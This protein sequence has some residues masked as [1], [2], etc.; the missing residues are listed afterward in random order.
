[1]KIRTRLIIALLV[2]LIAAMTFGTA[3]VWSSWRHSQEMNRIVT[4]AELSTRISSLVHETQ[5]ERGT[6]AG[7]LGNKSDEFRAR[8]QTQRTATDGQLKQ[9][10]GF[11][12][13]ISADDFGAEFS[14]ELTKAL[15]PLDKLTDVRKR[16]SAL[17]IPAPEAIGYYT[18]ANTSLL[19]VIGRAAT[20]TGDGP[21]AIRI[22]A[23]TSF[24]KSKERA[25]IERAVL[26]N[27][28]AQDSF[29]PG[30]YEK[31]QQLVALQDAY[32]A[33]FANHSSAQDRELLSEKLKAPCV[34]H[35]GEFRQKAIAT[36]ATG[37]FGVKATE[38][39]DT[40]TAKINLLKEVDDGLASRLLTEAR[41]TRAASDRLLYSLAGAMLVTLAVSSGLAYRLARS[42]LRRV[43][44][45]RDRLRGIAEG[46]AD[47]TLRLES[48]PDELGEVAKWFNKFM[49]RLEPTIGRILT[50]SAKVCVSAN[51]LTSTARALAT[52]AEE[53]KLGASSVASAVEELSSNMKHMASSTER[54]ADDMNI[55]A[56]SVR[57]MNGSIAG[58]AGSSVESAGVVGTA[59]E[60]VQRSNEQI[61]EFSTAAEAIGQVVNVIQDIAEQT[62]LLAL[63]AT[64]EA[65]RAGNAGRGF[66]VV[67][68][69][70][71]E[72][73]SQTSTATED[74]RTRISAIQVTA[75]DTVL[76]MG[77]IREVMT[78]IDEAA[79]SIA[80]AA[81]QQ[82]GAVQQIAARVAH[83]AETSQIIS[84]GV[85]QSAQACSEISRHIVNV[86]QVL[87]DTV[88]GA[89]RSN[90]AGQQLSDVANDLLTLMQGFKIRQADLAEATD[91]TAA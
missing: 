5:K 83:V 89:Q 86:D 87:Q 35:V 16:V 6:T 1:M 20:V 62:N 59:A 80:V 72:L 27:T 25:G 23:Y 64:I 8:L 42:I 79:K 53:S 3:G 81:D 70:V 60:L 11:L 68:S 85:T 61:R 57:L 28:F 71:K 12:A 51:E 84:S 52:G 38:W 45:L 19:D 30:M 91:A 75:R 49:D 76:A 21:I 15:K 67:A 50:G 24:L 17:D 55:M 88:T 36:H 47:L 82:T 41:E 34:V 78:R 77:N 39:F 44:I 2:P 54:M 63:N 10:N 9:L 22:G 66:S 48:S 90:G 40:I 58:I 26:S 74:I 65:A 69:E 29:G 4:L 32:L 37:G 73:A 14:A 7:F 18:G 43:S 13:T 31:F 33:E 46:E 56:E